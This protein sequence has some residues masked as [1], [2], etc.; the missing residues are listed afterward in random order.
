MGYFL[1]GRSVKMKTSFEYYILLA[2]LYSFRVVK[3]I[4]KQNA[5]FA[6]GADNGPRFFYFSHYN[7]M[8]TLTSSSPVEMFLGVCSNRS[9]SVG[10][11]WCTRVPREILWLLKKRRSSFY[12]LIYP[13][14]LK[15]TSLACKHLCITSCSRVFF[16]VLLINIKILIKPYYT[17]PY[18]DCITISISGNKCNI[19]TIYIY[20][21]IISTFDIFSLYL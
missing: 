11:S 20:R 3:I 12:Y 5:Q 15:E 1:G 16:C 4:K 18:I 19:Y 7:I 21:T 2:Y 9:F 10:Y 6:K 8:I 17:F 13:Y 14:R